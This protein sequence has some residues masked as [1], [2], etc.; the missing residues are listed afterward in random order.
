MIFFLIAG[1]A[2]PAFVFAAP[3]TFGLVCLI[4]M[5]P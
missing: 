1:T 5:W 4:V 3:G 2:T